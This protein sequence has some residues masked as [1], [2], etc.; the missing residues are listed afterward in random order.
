MDPIDKIKTDRAEARKLSDPN[1]DT[2]FLALADKNG[3]ASVRTLVL[4]EIGDRHFVLFLNRTSP[5]WKL[6]EAGAGYE[7][8]IW[9]PSRQRQY[10]V[11]GS[12]VEL[13]SSI[14]NVNW[15]RRPQGSKYLDYVYQEMA[16]Q[17]SKLNNRQ[18]LVEEVQRLKQVYKIDE[19]HAPTAV[20]GVQLVAS[21]I[22]ML[23]LNRDDRIHDRQLFTFAD[24]QWAAQVLVP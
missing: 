9:Y 19:M 14:V 10:R 7:L 1:A 13:D 11:Q 22:E 6:L 3:Q 8:L 21:R 18:Q 23:D 20:G 4:R 12:L 2:C 16:P 17:S 24:G 5:K 15:L